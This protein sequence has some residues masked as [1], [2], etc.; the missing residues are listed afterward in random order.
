MNSIIA[1]VKEPV[2]GRVKTRLCPPLSH[3]QAATVYSA[4]ARDVLMA[5]GAVPVADVEIGYDARPESGAPA[6]LR[7]SSAWFP[8]HGDDLGERMNAA[9][10]RA[11]ARGARRA[12]IVGSDIPDLEPGL[13]SD[14]FRFLKRHPLVLGP[15]DD[16]GY[17]LV[18]LTR[19][20]PE[21]FRS[22]AWSTAEVLDQTIGRAERLGLSLELLPSRRDVDTP[23]DLEALRARLRSNSQAALY[24]RQALA[25]LELAAGKGGSQ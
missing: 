7:D 16:G 6:W 4:F 10:E 12:V 17:Y 20:C 2:P 5:L 13:V 25:E 23:D 15:A 8:Q 22:M 21:L 24:T 9:F 19:P 1:F 14:A 11:F 18:G 3:A